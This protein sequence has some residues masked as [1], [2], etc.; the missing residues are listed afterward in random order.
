MFE[1][2]DPQYA[3]RDVFIIPQYSDIS[4]RKEVDVSCKL[5]KAINLNGDKEQAVLDIPVISAN[6][7]SVTD[8][9][10][11]NAMRKC[12][13]I[14]A[15]HRFMSIEENVEE[16]RKSMYGLQHYLEDSS[17]CFVSIG[18]NKE[19]YRARAR[20]LYNEGARYFVI[21][22]A[23]GDSIMMRE[24]LHWMR[25]E[26][27]SSVVI[28]A[29]NV[30]TKESYRNLATWGADIIKVGIAPGKV[31]LTKN[32]TGVTYPQFSAVMKCAEEKERLDTKTLLVADGGIQEIGDIAKALGAGADMAMCG[33]MFAGCKESASIEGPDGKK[34][35]RGMASKGAMKVIRPNSPEN[36]LPTP[37]GKQIF[38]DDSGSVGELM[39]HIRGGLQSSFS[40]VGARNLLQFQTRAR[41]GVRLHPAPY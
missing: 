40:Y 18:V 31:C 29:G 21:D 32:V 37:E 17:S 30:A 10:F 1:T 11:A 36:Q 26:F 38:V 13:G 28:M 3:F 39:T 8:G 27:G 4:S 14:G 25:D 24:T 33:S 7:D 16:F 15:I 2:E 19:D 9:N 5:P 6:M 20:A 23:H 34:I 35:Y 22:I 12:G 41:F